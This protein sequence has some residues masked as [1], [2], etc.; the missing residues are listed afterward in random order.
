M[1]KTVVLA[2]P[3][4]H[5]HRTAEENLG[6]GY[7][8]MIL[9]SAGYGV[10]IVDSWLMGLTQEEIVRRIVSI[11]DLLLVGISAYRSALEDS[12]IMV[13]NIK[14][15]INVPVIA[16]G[17]G[18][19]FFDEDFLRAGFDYVLRGEGEK[20]LLAFARGLSEGNLVLDEIPGISF[21]HHGKLS[22]GSLPHF[23]EQLD[24][25]LFPARDTITKT[26]Q[27]KNPVAVSTSR[28]CFGRCFF[29]AVSAFARYQDGKVRWRART[30]QN[31]VDELEIL[32]SEYGIICFKF[33]DDSFLEPPRDQH[34]IDAF[35]KALRSR[36]LKIT[37][38]TQIRADRVTDNIVEALASCGW[39][40]TSLGVENWSASA[41]HRMNKSASIEDNLRAVE[42]LQKYG[43]YVQMGMILFDWDTTL[44][45]LKDNFTFLKS[46]SWPVTKGIFT[47]MYVS[48]GVPNERFLYSRSDVSIK[49]SSL[50]HIEYHPHISEVD[51]V[52][53]ALK[54]WHSSHSQVYDHAINPVTAPK[55]IE[56][57]GYHEYHQKCRYLYSM[58]LE[59]FGQV[60]EM[61]ENGVSGAE[62]LKETAKAIL[63]FQP[64]YERIELEVCTLDR[65]YGIHYNAPP[66]PFLGE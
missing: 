11:P 25:L 47:E 31:I 6:L 62:V 52:Y 22:R 50:G 17:Y 29:C 35:S 46:L 64:D 39:F 59:F 55:A 51:T 2:T 21:L 38:R 57:V 18:P 12:A 58:D 15:C 9:R 32:H 23:V 60:L 44:T 65:C 13:S 56:C 54:M 8:A 37:F 48:T 16:G 10:K 19:T 49:K 40:A 7:L 30:I 43:V 63:Q 14:S 33:V 27:L 5:T 28:G 53:N 42:Y 3:P 24:S 34:W 61:V 36:G 1:N 41:L 4:S 26:I 66:N 45:E 20:S